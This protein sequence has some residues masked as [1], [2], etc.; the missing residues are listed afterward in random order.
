ML[1]GLLV[2]ALFACLDEKP[3]RVRKCDDNDML[4]ACSLARGCLVFGL[5]ACLLACLLGFM[6][7]PS[8]KISE[9]ENKY[10]K[11]ENIYGKNPATHF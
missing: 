3:V 9:T 2:A 11:T 1:A 6:L 7:C 4:L 5:L 8:Q 10:K